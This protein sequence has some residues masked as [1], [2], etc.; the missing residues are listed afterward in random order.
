MPP[1][2]IVRCAVC[3]EPVLPHSHDVLRKVQGWVERRS[4]G[5]TNAL[6]GRVELHE[7]AHRGC[8][9]TSSS[10]AQGEQASLW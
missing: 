5:G 3:G 8:I 2:A 4:Q 9:R 10:A 1:D 6:R 7:Y